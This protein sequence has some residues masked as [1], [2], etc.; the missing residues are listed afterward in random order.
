VG[1]AQAAREIEAVVAD[2]ARG[3]RF[4]SNTPPKS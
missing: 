3:D 1:A 2:F 4:L